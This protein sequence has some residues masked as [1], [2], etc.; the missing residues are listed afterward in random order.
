MDSRGLKMFAVMAIREGWKKPRFVWEGQS[1]QRLHIYQRKRS[2]QQ[3]AGVM[4]C[5]TLPRG[6]AFFQVGY[7]DKAH[8]S[9]KLIEVEWIVVP[10]WTES[11]PEVDRG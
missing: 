7:H 11:I 3:Q 10:V 9:P 2:A 8:N 4:N 5:T 1:H 6:K